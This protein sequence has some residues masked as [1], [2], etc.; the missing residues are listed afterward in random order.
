MTT[1]P[2]GIILERA[3]HVTT[4]V[5]TSLSGSG[6]QHYC[7]VPNCG[8]DYVSL[9][10]PD[11]QL[12]VLRSRRPPHLDPSFSHHLHTGSR[13][14]CIPKFRKDDTTTDSEVDFGGLRG[15]GAI[16][17]INHLPV[18]KSVSSSFSLCTETI[19]LRHSMLTHGMNT[20]PVEMAGSRRKRMSKQSGIH[21]GFLL[22]FTSTLS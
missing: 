4:S 22:W 12:F 3:N 1:R 5:Q 7:W 8:A 13:W 17:I 15:Q 11:G 16:S 2:S 10:W 20:I 21:S 14:W 19:R 6:R 9:V 18:S